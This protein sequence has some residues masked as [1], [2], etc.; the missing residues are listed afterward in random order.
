MKKK[1]ISKEELRWKGFGWFKGFKVESGVWRYIF[2]NEV[3]YR[4]LCGEVLEW[5]EVKV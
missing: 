5:S 3:W 1:C 4:Y 2:V